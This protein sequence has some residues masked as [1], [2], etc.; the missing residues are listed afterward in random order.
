LADNKTQA[1]RASVRAF[2]DAIDDSERRADAKKVAA[3]MR[4]ATDCRATMW[5]KDIIGYGKYH[6]RYASGRE[7]DW[8][9]VGF[10]PRKRNLSIYIMP[11]FESYGGLLEKLGKYKTGRSCLTINSLADVDE[12]V[13]E[14]L[15][16]DSVATMRER[17]DVK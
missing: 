10:S 14:T 5:G 11:G 7:G 16:A 3:M 13:L 4:N 2:L 12:K 8:M 15:I 6:Y 1:T 9:L 17:Y